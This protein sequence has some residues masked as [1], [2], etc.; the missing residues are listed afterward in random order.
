MVSNKAVL[1]EQRV[2]AWFFWGSEI[3]FVKKLIQLREKLVWMPE[4]LSSENSTYK[5]PGCEIV[6]LILG[7]EN[8]SAK[9]R[10]GTEC[11]QSL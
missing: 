6:W 11:Q 1:T 9:Q 8:I 3:D 10:G 7:L 2:E 4:R 5:F